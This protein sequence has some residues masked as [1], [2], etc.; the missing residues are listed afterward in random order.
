MRLD[1]KRPGQPGRGAFG[2]TR[3]TCLVPEQA[4]RPAR[5]Y[6]WCRTDNAVTP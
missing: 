4:A 5:S 6:H 3:G 1:Q 2:L